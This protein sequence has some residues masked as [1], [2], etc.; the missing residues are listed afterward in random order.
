[1]FDG[2]KDT[3]KTVNFQKKE[4]TFAKKGVPF[5]Q[6]GVPFAGNEARFARKG[7]GLSVCISSTTGNV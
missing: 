1:M 3:K 4:V 6:K 2:C 7:V 5:R